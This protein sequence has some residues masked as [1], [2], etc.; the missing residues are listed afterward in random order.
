[1]SDPTESTAPGAVR[2]SLDDLD[3]MIR[4]APRRMWL[5]VTAIGLIAVV[6]IGLGIFGRTSVIVTGTGVMLPADGLSEVIPVVHGLLKNV[7]VRTGDRVEAGQVVGSVVTGPGTTT[8]VTSL[9]SGIVVE[10]LV[11]PGDAVGPTTPIARVQSE[12][13]RLVAYTFMPVDQGQEITADMPVNVA[14]DSAPSEQYGMV[15]GTVTGISL[16]P[17]ST[18]RLE[19]LAGHS[20]TLV[21]ILQSQGPSLETRVTLETATTPSGYRWTTGRG[22]DFEITAGTVLRPTIVLSSSSLV[23]Q[24]FS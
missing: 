12:Q 5:N 13:G 18:E 19:Y 24:V 10:L 6:A 20:R 22:P 14:V 8:E 15:R 21:D 2:P 3:Q 23:S 4:L 7:A 9:V 11:G 17:V 1:M 16:L